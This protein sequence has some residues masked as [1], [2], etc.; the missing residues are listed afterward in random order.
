MNENLEN[1]EEEFEL[2]PSKAQEAIGQHYIFQLPEEECIMA[3]Q[4]Q[5]DMFEQECFSILEQLLK[6][7]DNKVQNRS[8]SSRTAFSDRI[9]PD[10][11]LQLGKTPLPIISPTT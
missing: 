10:F 9:N 3:L 5:G 1:F 11:I 8:G 7:T 4:E 2:V 6:N